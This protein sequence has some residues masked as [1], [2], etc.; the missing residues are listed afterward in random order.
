MPAVHCMVTV[1]SDV[2]VELLPS[3]FNVP[4][5]FEVENPQRPPLV[6]IFPDAVRVPS[7]SGVNAIYLT[8]SPEAAP[9]RQYCK[10]IIVFGKSA[11]CRI[12][13][14]SITGKIPYLCIRR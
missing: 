9:P 3:A 8:L 12:Y 14:C 7:F 5:S 6:F 4:T 2:L 10:P 11:L 1:L 13:L